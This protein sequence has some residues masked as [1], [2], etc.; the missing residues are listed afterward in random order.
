MKRTL[1][2]L[3]ALLLMAGYATAG[4][5]FVL[6]A[7]VSNYQNSSADLPTTTNDAKRVAKVWQ[8]HSKDVSLITSRYATHEKLLSK[9]KEIA[10][11]AGEDDRIVFFFSGHGNTG[12]VI[13]YDMKPLRYT[14]IID[15]LS[16]SKAVVKMVFIDACKAG[17]ATTL[18]ESEL[19][20][21]KL[22]TGNIVFML[23]SRAEEVSAADNFLTA[24]WFSH[25]YLKGIEGLADANKDRSITVMELFT[26]IYNDVT[27]RSKNAQHPQLIATKEHQNDAVLTW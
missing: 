27:K 4:R 9:L 1:I 24:G 23:A 21:E 8:K 7:G 15:V 12:A 5:T 14:E 16:T 26:Y 18:G 22:K 17:S 13:T 20:R 11:A 6:V 19:W 10:S 25:A 2:I 3:T